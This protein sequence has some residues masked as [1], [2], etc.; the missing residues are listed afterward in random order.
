M[1]AQ[2]DIATEMYATLSGRVEDAMVKRL[3]EKMAAAVTDG[4]KTLHLMI[5]SSGGVIGDGIAI[6]N[7]LRNLPI[8]I[9][10]YNGGMVQS[11]AVI[12]FLAASRRKA[13]K[14]A[15]FMIHKAT[16]NA[17]LP[18]TS[19]QLSTVAHSL[20]VDDG[21]IEDILKE[22]LSMPEDKWNVHRF[23]D[24]F[25]TAEE[26]LDFGLIDEIADF[27]PPPGAVLMNI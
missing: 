19:L 23:S 8:D 6:Y 7:Y 15:T 22:Y 20:M 4:V 13:S 27:A 10:A 1:G 25:I 18:T 21:R 17:G 24:L 5:Q 11:I 12:A 16:F 14:T 9:I 26:A 3:F 2:P